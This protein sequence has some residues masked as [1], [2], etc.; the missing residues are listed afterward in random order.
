MS[1]E[2][3]IQKTLN[4][5]LQT[6]SFDRLTS[7]VE[8][9]SW[10]VMNQDEKKLLA[11]LF[12]M[13][14][15]RELKQ[16]TSLDPIAAAKKSFTTALN[17]AP[18]DPIIWYRRGLAFSLQDIPSLLEEGSLCFEK[19]ISLKETFFD[20]WYAWGNVLVRR[21]VV[22][23]EPSFFSQAEEKFKKAESLLE[24]VDEQNEFYWH[25]GLAYFMIGR[26]SGEAIDLHQ[27]VRCYR[28]AR[29]L[30]LARLDFYNDFANALVELSLLINCQELLFEAIELYLHSLDTNDP[31][32]DSAREIAVRYCNLGACY[33]YLFEFHHEETFFKQ[34]QECFA[35]ATK[36]NANF[37]NAW[38]FW[39]YLLLYAAKL[40]QDV[41]FLESCLDKFSRL[42]DFCE[43]K[44]MLLA[45]MSEA[46][47]IYGSHHEDLKY[48]TDADEIAKA[49]IEAG[50]DVPYTWSSA[51]LANLEMGRYFGDD[52]YFQ[53]AIEHSEKALAINP[54]IGMSAHILAVAKFS[55]GETRGELD[56]MQEA[57][58]AFLHASKS[59]VGRFGYLWNDWGIAL[60]NLA[61][62]T[63]EK[64]YVQEAIEKFEQGLLLHE[65]VNPAWL[66]N[67]GSALD[68]WGDLTDDESYYEKA[69][70]VLN[71]AL[72]LDT[73]N[74]QARYHLGLALCHLGE[75]TS[76]LATLQKA[77]IELQQVLQEDVEDDTAWNDLGMAFLHV[78]EMTKD[79][80]GHE[81]SQEVQTSLLQLGEQHF[82]QALSLGNQHVYYNLACVSALLGKEQET[83]FYL[84]KG[85]ACQLLPP[86][87]EIIE[88]EW[89]D[90]IKD[91]PSFQE[92]LNRLA[93]QDDVSQDDFSHDDY[94][95][96]DFSQDDFR[97]DDLN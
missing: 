4:D 60:L 84:E 78:A 21:G 1:E 44:P 5:I 93:K 32:Q 19:A 89:L 59:E 56:L 33:Q 10:N 91:V 45:R 86:L 31:S 30:G 7:F 35:N 79:P 25:Y 69:I 39:G 65:H 67:Y 74:T 77:I 53:T 27:A 13:A 96:D 73:T 66:V 64:R 43:D 23:N 81:S 57:V 34:A 15:E 26:H 72:S 71:H 40:W 50:S 47:S 75:L 48:L 97:H 87:A 8:A 82:L 3:P 6:Q 92:F 41:T 83:L 76:D 22:L 95:E 70:E 54:K 12:V 14:A 28:K 62:I 90:S 37:G 18:N 24:H 9:E 36:H 88:D 46:F 58:N 11:K 20:A 85:A 55:L 68:Y 2:T 29:D 38:A 49:A 52:K 61:D 51:A 63:H 17:L 42:A 16:P 80:S 94:N